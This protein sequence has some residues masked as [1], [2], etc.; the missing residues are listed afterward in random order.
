M[1]QYRCCYDDDFESWLCFMTELW[2]MPGSNSCRTLL[3]LPSGSMYIDVISSFTGNHDRVVAVPDLAISFFYK[4]IEDNC[5]PSL[6]EKG[7]D[8]YAAASIAK[9]LEVMDQTMLY[10]SDKWDS[11]INLAGGHDMIEFKPIQKS[12]IFS[13]N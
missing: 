3:Q 2:H 11:A 7:V 13:K 10:S 9:T 5:I 6:T 4:S 8:Q 12:S 1:I